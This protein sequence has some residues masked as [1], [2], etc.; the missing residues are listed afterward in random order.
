MAFMKPALTFAIREAAV[1]HLHLTAVMCMMK[2]AA[3]RRAVPAAI[4]AQAAMQS[5]SPARTASA[6]MVADITVPITDGITV[7][8]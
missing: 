1:F 3:T 6:T 8:F 2:T 7:N 5:S 4:P